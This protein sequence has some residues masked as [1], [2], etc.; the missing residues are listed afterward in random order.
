MKKILSVLVVLA[1]AVVMSASASMVM[2][3][4]VE[5]L[6][7]GQ[8]YTYGEYAVSKGLAENAF[9]PTTFASKLTFGDKVTY[10]SIDQ[11]LSTSITGKQ[12][13][14]VDRQIFGQSGAAYAAYNDLKAYWDPENPNTALVA[15]AGI[16]KNQFA[17]FSGALTQVDPALALVKGTQ[18]PAGQVD[19]YGGG[20]TLQWWT[21]AG[22]QDPSW[23]TKYSDNAQV[24]TPTATLHES[25]TDATV[26]IS[27]NPVA[28]YSLT[29]NPMNVFQIN[30]PTANPLCVG[31][32]EIWVGNTNKGM[33]ADVS[34]NAMLPYISVTPALG[35]L[36]AQLTELGSSMDSDVTL[37]QT[38]A[39][40]AN[41]PVMTTSLAGTSSLNAQFENAF[42]SPGV[43]LGVS[44]NTPTPVKYWWT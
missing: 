12:I 10:G 3:S 24:V 16:T 6:S 13:G 31:Q 36:D 1:I 32:S 18:T 23:T 28:T 15:Q 43:L 39:N 9:T 17:A 14:S 37:V 42:L 20:H 34:G 11:S 41:G 38:I 7:P 2:P 8:S 44:F 25:A 40:N 5:N 21:L 19:P 29:P 26:T 35:S 4:W 27:A 30:E 22:G 33:N